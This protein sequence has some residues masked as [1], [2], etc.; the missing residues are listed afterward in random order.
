[1]PRILARRVGSRLPIPLSSTLIFASLVAARLHL[2][3]GR[4]A[5]AIRMLGRARQGWPVPG[6]LERRLT[7]AEAGAATMGG[8]AGAA[9]AAADRCGGADELDVATARAAAWMA[10]GEI[11]AARAALRGALERAGEDPEHILDPSLLEALLLDARIHY[12][13]GDRAAGRDSLVRALRIGRSEDV[14]LPFAMERA[15]IVPVLRTDAELTAGYQ[16]LFQPLQARNGDDDL[17]SLLT[18][19]GQSPVVEPLTG[20]EREVLRRVAQLMSTAEIANELYISVNT[21]KTHLKSV[22]RKLA[23]THRREAVRRAQQ[24]KLI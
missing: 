22:H 23:V 24:L 19:L 13:V 12:A 10:A 4:H 20:R 6:W 9:L 3:E 2:A 21:V 1:M 5:V 17:Q 7:L 16:A 11:K 18:E 15:W 14:R 8:D